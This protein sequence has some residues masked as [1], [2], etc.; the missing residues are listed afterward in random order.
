MLGSDV[1]DV[2]H[3]YGE[4]VHAF[5]RGDLDIT[6]RAAV[7]AAVDELQPSIVVNCAAYTRV[8]DAETDEETA[9]EINAHG[10]AHL[11]A[12]CAETGA[13]LLHVSTD[14]VF[15]GFADEPYAEKAKPAPRT[16]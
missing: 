12:A 5:A 2:L 8:D 4:E 14:Y 15:D 10:P 1:V 13:R 16:A 3:A 11:A 6:D 9:Y 7:V